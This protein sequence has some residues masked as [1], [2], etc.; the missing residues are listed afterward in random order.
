MNRRGLA[1]QGRQWL[2]ESGWRERLKQ[3]VV[4][5]VPSR[6]L[7]C[8]QV[9]HRLVERSTFAPVTCTQQKHTVCSRHPGVAIAV[10]SNPIPNPINVRW[11][12]A[13]EN[14]PTFHRCPSAVTFIAQHQEQFAWEH[15]APRSRT[16]HTSPPLSHRPSYLDTLEG[17]IRGFAALLLLGV[18]QPAKARAGTNLFLYLRAGRRQRGGGEE[19]VWRLAAHPQGPCS[20]RAGRAAQ[21]KRCPAARGRRWTK[22]MGSAAPLESP[23]SWAGA[24]GDVRGAR[25]LLDKLK[26]WTGQL[27]T[28]RSC[29]SAF[30]CRFAVAGER[31]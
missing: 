16:T 22:A 5:C 13:C 31:F 11:S 28:E 10:N 18:A 27:G 6:A 19:V 21:G 25:N 23:P 17:L 1:Y 15:Q 8:P 2:P 14:L 12:R 7:M 29:A 30:F 20:D 26:S 9:F 4:P 24:Q 3:A